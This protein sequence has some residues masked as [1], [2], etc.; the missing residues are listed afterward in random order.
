MQSRVPLGPGKF[1]VVVLVYNELHSFFQIVCT[2]YMQFNHEPSVKSTSVIGHLRKGKL[3]LVYPERKVVAGGKIV[4]FFFISTLCY[5]LL[6]RAAKF[7]SQ[8]LNFGI[9]FSQIVQS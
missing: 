8:R 4:I 9:S 2:D 6:L 7:C 5:A 1:H 3:K